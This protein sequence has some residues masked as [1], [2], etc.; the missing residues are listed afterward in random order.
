MITYAVPLFMVA[1]F[2]GLAPMA[3]PIFQVNAF[4][5]GT[6][7]V[8]P[9]SANTGASVA[10]R[11]A[12]W[13][14]SIARRMSAL[15][16]NQ[17]GEVSL[18]VLKDAVDASNRLFNEFKQANETRLK[19]IETGEAIDPLIEGKL[20]KISDKLSELATITDSVSKLEARM[21]RERLNGGSGDEQKKVENDTKSFNLLLRG[22]ARQYGRE[23]KGELSV[24]QYKEYREASVKFLRY[25]VDALEPN[26]RR[27]M[28][29]GSDPDGGYLVNPDMTGQVVKKLFE[30][31]PMRQICA[32][33]TISTDALEGLKDTDEAS[34]GWVA[35]QGARTATNTPQLG[36]WRIPVM[37]C[38]A[39][40]GATQSLLDDANIDVEAWLAGKVAD[41]LARGTN[42][43]FV[44]GTGV[45]QPRGFA[46]YTT[47]ATADASRSWGTLEHVATGTSAA[48]AR[49]RTAPTS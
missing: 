12:I 15:L 28:S 37:E 46:S 10:A 33:Q 43:A 9:W 27:A 38:Y 25:G 4:N 11:V 14:S 35:E 7:K 21:N 41:K 24:E 32:Q 48:T 3:L 20:T 31:S 45:G 18:A 26:E 1:L 6:V 30:T 36:K 42:T 22:H 44:V 16:G 29:V 34:F 19:A 40:P 13:G 5:V 49:T 17:K 23:F 8:A 47:A 39:N 2:I